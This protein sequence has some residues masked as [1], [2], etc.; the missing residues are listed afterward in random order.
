MPHIQATSLQ[1]ALATLD[2]ALRRLLTDFDTHTPLPRMF[3]ALERTIH[4]LA[5]WFADTIFASFLFSVLENTDLEARVLA[6]KK[7]HT[8]AWKLNRKREVTLMLLGGHLVT[9]RGRAGRCKRQKGRKR[10]TGKRGK[11]SG[12]ANTPI[13]EVF[14]FVRRRSPALAAEELVASASLESYEKGR[15]QL[16]RRGIKLSQSSF[17]RDI[18]VMGELARDA[19]FHWLE[20]PKTPGPFGGLSA[21]GCRIVIAFD[22]GRLRER[23]DK[24]G[25][26][27]LNGYRDFEAPWVEP[28][29]LVIY[30]IDEDG[31]PCKTFGKLA[32]ASLAGPDELFETMGLW[33]AA[34][35]L[36][37]AEQVIVVADGQHWQWERM[38]TVLL[39]VGVSEDKLL[40]VLDKSHAKGRL[41][42][43]AN[44]PNWCKNKRIRWL[45]QTRAMLRE[46]RIEELI[47]A[48]L[49]LAKGRRA[50][51]IKSLAGYFR[52]HQKRMRY[53]DFEAM[54]VPLGSGAVESMIR[55]V[56]NLRLKGCGK[57]WKREN[58]ERMLL[59]RSFLV[60][61]RLD[62]LVDF[63]LEHRVAWWKDA[64][65][66]NSCASQE[67]VV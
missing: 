21:M 32:Y 12:H 49:A 46:G 58:A 45:L 19:L 31:E 65:D 26:K 40:E 37:E 23:I 62:A 22:G 33:F 5:R 42:E 18:E 8:P 20:D 41:Y 13:L 14:G 39:E 61:V 1:N 2:F 43:V 67:V 25:R 64:L 55:Q 50:K 56:I 51:V 24:K 47:E 53:A 3:A 57:F 17:L 11:T 7:A 35:R 52:E 36:A 54:G 38:R 48:C 66:K 16:S 6:A 9:L 44:V 60:T 30:A 15:D 10:G 63:A 28:R 59:L 27:K 34:I 29:Q 4:A